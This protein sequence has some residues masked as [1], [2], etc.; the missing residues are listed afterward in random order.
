MATPAVQ[1][2]GL[3]E[4]K[5]ALAG[6]A[7]QVLGYTR[8]GAQIS[9]DGFFENVPGDENG[10]DAGPPVDV[11]YLGEIARVRLELTKWVAAVADQVVTRVSGATT[12]RPSPAGTLMFADS[13]QFRVVVN[14]PTTPLNFPRCIVRA[15]YEINKGTVYSRLVLEF[16]AHKDSS[17]VL[18]NSTVT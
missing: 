1:V 10:G 15:P 11:Q 2:A 9:A 5:I 14:S 17:G 8:Q 16:E 7:L 6:G 4:I 12:G 13:K 3:A 18:F